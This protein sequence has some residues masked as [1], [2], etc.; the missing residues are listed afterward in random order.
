MS[1]TLRIAFVLDRYDAVG[2]GAQRWTHDHAQRLLQDGHHVHIYARAIKGA[3]AGARTHVVEF[4]SLPNTRRLRF[5]A[6][7]ERMLAQEKFDIVHDMGDGWHADVMMPHHGIRRYVYQQR[8]RLSHGLV[9]WARPLG[10]GLLPRYR[11]FRALER[12]QYARK[13]APAIVA[14]SEMVRRQLLS[15]YPIDP[16][17]VVV[18]HNGVDLDRFRPDES[19]INRD[20]IRSEMKWQSR[21]IYL[22]VAHDFKLKG[23]DRILSAMAHLRGRGRD[24]GLIVIGGGDIPKYERIA[25]Q[26][27]V[28][29]DVVFMGDQEDPV[30]YYH[31]SDVFVLPTL[32]DPCPLV[33]MEALACGLPVITT[34]YNGATELMTLPRDG[35]VLNDPMNVMEL[36]LAMLRFDEAETARL[37]PE[38]AAASRRA[39]LCAKRMYEKHLEVYREILRERGRSLPAAARS[40]TR[41]N[42]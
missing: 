2:G 33:V 38:R 13:G 10:F 8:S 1:G 29:G 9:R 19:G 35:V 40:D 27:G 16:A 7:V 22:T 3:P 17:R 28:A 12:R 20:Q 6:A 23:V 15:T 26:I 11:E 25:R 18:I 31:A 42:A 32:Y 5:A 36:A 4:G 39:D 24:A 34:S 30:P 41:V 21:T 37:A 14:V